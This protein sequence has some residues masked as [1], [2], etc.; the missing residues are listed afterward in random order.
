[1]LQIKNF[2]QTVVSLFGP[3]GNY[4]GEIE[5]GMQFNDVRI[6]IAGQRL[7]G[8]HITYQNH[9]QGKLERID[10]KP[11][12]D[13]EKWPS[14]LYDEENNQLKFLAKIRMAMSEK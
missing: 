5:N 12:G 14:G 6:Q 2:K 10:I 4:I 9:E 3:D 7:K 13:L 8:C 11:N 1:M